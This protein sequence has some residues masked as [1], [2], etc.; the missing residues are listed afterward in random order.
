ML[1]EL[2]ETYCGLFTALYSNR[3]VLPEKQYRVMVE[4]LF[5]AYRRDSDM[6]ILQMILDTSRERYALRF[7]MRNY[8]PRGAWIFANKSARRMQKACEEDFK[9][10]L[11]Q[12]EAAV[13]AADP[14]PPEDPPRST[15]TLPVAVQ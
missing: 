10:Y 3:T 1:R 6:I 7:K 13:K 9:K 5:D 14:P 12:L 8:V 15:T 2:N 11:L 4:H